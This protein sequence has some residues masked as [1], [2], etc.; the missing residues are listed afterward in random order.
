MLATIVSWF[1]HK[2]LTTL[3][4]Q[5]QCEEKTLEEDKNR[6]LSV[7]PIHTDQGRRFRTLFSIVFL[8]LRW[9][10]QDDLHYDHEDGFQSVEVRADR[11]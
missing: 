8:R 9:S 7:S 4:L 1:K 3:V 6:Y 2:M 11:A 5:I 10:Q